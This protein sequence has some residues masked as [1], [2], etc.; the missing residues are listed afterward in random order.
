MPNLSPQARAIVTVFAQQ[1]GV[2][3][4]QANNLQ[5]VIN[6][7]PA[8]IDQINNAVAQGHLRQIV[9]LANSHAGGEYDGQGKQMRLPLAALTTPPPQVRAFDAGE[10]TFVLGHELQHGFNHAATRQAYRDFRH[11]ANLKAQETAAPRDYT[12]AVET[13]IAANR[14]NEAGAEIAGW[15]A[16]VSMV[17]SSTPNP[18]LGDIHEAQRGRIADF[19]DKSQTTPPVYALKSNLTLNPDL[20]L[21]PTPANLEAMGQHF[22]DKAPVD[23][24]LGHRGNSDYANYY[25]AWA[26][27]AVAGLERHHNPPRPGVGTAPMALDLA[28]LGLNEKLLEEN[29]IHLGNNTQP[30]PYFDRSTQ[31]P[32]LGL[33]QHTYLSHQHTSPVSAQAFEA[34]LA[35][36]QSHPTPVRAA[37]P[38]HPDHPDHAMLEQIRA[39]VRAIDAQHNRTYDDISERISRGLLVAC[40]DHRDQYPDCPT[41]ISQT[42]LGRVDHVILGSN[43]HMIAVEGDLDDPT[44]KRAAVNIDQAVATPVEQWDRKLQAAN[45]VIGRERELEQQYSHARSLDPSQGVPA[46]QGM[47]R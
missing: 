25:G 32:A 14:R 33:F 30:M 16:V 4:D 43:S 40:R 5:A 10:V 31:P 26:I 8:L 23:T 1:P 47:S 35:R 3:H 45:E 46:A 42:G 18:T 28:Q 19:V 2:T 11:D 17:K 20:T 22:F 39:G 29:G 13:L 24:R 38:D 44:H 37:G 6:A 15:N 21:S 12:T 9:P 34:E 41:Q 7:S 36:L 27:S